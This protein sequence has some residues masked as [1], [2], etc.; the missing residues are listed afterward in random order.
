MLTA[1]YKN[2]YPWRNLD[3]FLHVIRGTI[4]YKSEDNSLVAICK[5][6]G[7]GTYLVEDQNL[8]NQNQDK[9]LFKSATRPRYCIADTLKPL[10]DEL[11]PKQPYQVLKG[12]DRYMSG[13]VLLS[14]NLEE[15]RKRF[16][17]A[18]SGSRSVKMPPY[19]FRAIAQGYP[20]L[21]S[22]RICETVGI[23]QIE[24]D[25]LGDYKEPVVV[26]SP[27]RR[28]R[29][30][31]NRTLDTFQADLEIKKVNKELSVSLL[32]LYVSKLSHDF[33]RCYISSKTSFILGDVR[34]SKR[35]KEILGKQIQVS[36]YRSSHSHDNYEPL[37]S[38]LRKILGVDRNASIPLM[39]DL[40]AIR[41]KSFVRSAQGRKDLTIQSKLLPPHFELTARKLDLLS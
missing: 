4:A 7:V 2:L 27:P 14:N 25:E 26:Q 36:A 21:K 18:L 1:A 13:L 41:L 20:L 17:N 32:E 29:N 10:T 24:V 19:G 6:L 15:H 5:P 28:F 16:H 30:K 31:Y 39:L 23:E 33:P 34:F 9:F 38:K 3:E 22:N 12:I 35:I 11:S 8:S 40:H 37:N